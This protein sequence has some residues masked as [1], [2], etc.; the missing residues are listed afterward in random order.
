MAQRSPMSTIFS[1]PNHAYLVVSNRAARLDPTYAP[2]FAL[3]EDGLNSRDPEKVGV[4]IAIINK[5]APKTG[6]TFM[7]Q[8]SFL[9]TLEFFDK[10]ITIC[11]EAGDVLANKSIW[12]AP[13]YKDSILVISKACQTA[14]PELMYSAVQAFDKLFNKPEE[15]EVFVY[16]ASLREHFSR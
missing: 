9:T 2:G 8:I 13:K 14:N 7:L 3:I 6:D 10:G 16:F 12:F 11:S 5:A 1:V 15:K 4:G